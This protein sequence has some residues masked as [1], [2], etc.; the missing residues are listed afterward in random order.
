MRIAIIDDHRMVAESLA[1]ALEAAPDGFSVVGLATDGAGA[2]RLV[3]EQTPDVALL[4]VLLGD[5]WGLDVGRRLAAASPQTAIVYFSAYA[6][7]DFIARALDQGAAGYVTKDGSFA[8]LIAALRTVREGGRAFAPLPRQM[9]AA[10]RRHVAPGD[11]SGEQSMSDREREVFRRLAAGESLSETSKALEI[12]TETVR[13]L[14]KRAREKL[15]LESFP[16]RLMRRG[17]PS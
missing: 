12:D 5:D 11:S 10:M 7:P 14:W 1:R 6:N 17:K 4:D 2:L 15:G 8:D 16:R 9:A 13:T 3:K